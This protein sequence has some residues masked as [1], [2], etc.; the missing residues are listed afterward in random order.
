MIGDGKSDL[1]RETLNLLPN[2]VYIR[3]SDQVW[4][5][6]NEA[7]CRF[8]GQRREDLIGRADTGSLPEDQAGLLREL[9]AH[10]LETRSTYSGT[11]QLT[12]A[13]GDARWMDVA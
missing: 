9:D 11:E 13:E 1:L 8:T 4:V 2:P 12:N 7:F 10:I 6:V 5:E 3:R